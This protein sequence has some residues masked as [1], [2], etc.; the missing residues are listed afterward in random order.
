MKDDLSKVAEALGLP[1]RGM[2][3]LAR[4][5]RPLLALPHGG[6]AALRTLRLY[7]PQ[8]GLAK[9]TAGVLRAASALGAHRSL[10]PKASADISG[11][12]GDL[13]P[14]G[15]DYDTVG[16]LFGSS[17]HRVFRAVLSYRNGDSWEVGKLA[18]GEDGAAML[19]MEALALRDLS[20][21]VPEAP[22]LLG[23]EEAGTARLLRM[24][25]L[26]GSCLK[27]G[28]HGPIS[29]LLPSWLSD[30]APLPLRAFPEWD[31]IRSA[32]IV[33]PHGDRSLESLG[34]IVLRPSVR[35]GDLARWNL[36]ITKEGDLKVLDW[37]WGKRHG[38]PGIDLVHYLAQDFRLVQRLSPTDVVEKTVQS[39]N[40]PIWRKYLDQTG[41]GD[42]TRELVIACLAFKHGA[43]HQDNE[44]ILRVA[45]F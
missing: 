19:E 11:D 13:L 42:L 14:K 3:L 12:F 24:P 36:L 17:E 18:A 7:Q 37:E 34:D 28:D 31:S 41:W 22:K 20:Q 8:R 30:D 21:R 2:H 35:H 45:R 26:T 15:T 23:L 4:G 40:L 10:L 44:Q 43:G 33:V 25:Y 1:L 9:L 39:L 32:L 16:I 5:G 38:L 29:R 27:A 6:E